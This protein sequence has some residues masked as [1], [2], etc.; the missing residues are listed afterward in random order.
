MGSPIV[1]PFFILDFIWLA[2]NKRGFFQHWLD[3]LVNGGYE[4]A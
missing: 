1:E 3:I 4:H 2:F